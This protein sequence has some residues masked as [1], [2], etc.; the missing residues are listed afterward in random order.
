MKRKA[1]IFLVE[2]DHNFGSVLKAYLEMNDY[3]VTWIDDGKDALIEFGHGDF[4]I[5]VLDVML[6]NVDGYAIAEG[7]RKI[8]STVPFIFLTAKTLKADILK[9]YSTGAD[10]YV[11][12]PFDSEVLICKIDAILSRAAGIASSTDETVFV[13]GQYEFNPDLREIK[14]GEIA[15]KL[16]PKES[17]L[18]ALLCKHMNEVLPR[19]LA[20]RTIWGEEGYFT[21]RS[22]DVF[23]TKLRKYLK[24]DPSVEILN[25]HGNGFRLLVKEDTS[26]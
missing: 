23:I 15:I 1:T 26:R 2:D 7:I 9:G 5:C 22:M 24:D 21:T 20:L 11:T 8:R 18:L 3:A 4:D 16:S 6:P 25:I 12:K 17:E 13:L 19:E 14:R 10:D